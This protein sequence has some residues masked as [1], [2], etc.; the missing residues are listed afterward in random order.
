MSEIDLNYVRPMEKHLLKICE[1]V[2][3]LKYDESA[4]NT[5]HKRDL[6]ESLLEKMQ[7]SNA[8]FEKL[9]ESLV[10][11][12]SYPDNIKI[13]EPNEYDELVVLKFPSPRVARSR[14]GYV[15]INISDAIRKGWNIG[16]ENYDL[17]V[18]D[19]GYLIQNKVL[20]W[21]RH[22]VRSTLQECDNVIETDEDSYE[23][24]QKSNG[25][26]VTL[27]VTVQN[28]E[29]EFSVDFVGCLAFHSDQCWMS[30]LRR[31]SG[32]WNAIPKPIKLDESM[33][34][35]RMNSAVETSD[36]KIQPPF[37]KDVAPA[38]KVKM[39]SR[40]ENEKLGKIKRPPSYFWIKSAN[41][42]E[43]PMSVKKILT[44]L[45]YALPTETR[46]REIPGQALGT[47]NRRSPKLMKRFQSL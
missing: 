25:P 12:G 28:E 36:P 5:K 44:R 3:K 27:D 45:M 21:I 9:F 20:Q 40:N 47:E 15:T 35:Q 39:V 1:N 43:N 16:R 8:I 31:H 10:P 11:A 29:I 23:V 32:I 46:E 4:T 19:K 13:S 14:P 34:V 2:I 26:A 22:V 33:A 38:Q 17:F 30:D 41:K 7:E 37:N 18:D 6:C 42:S 24:I